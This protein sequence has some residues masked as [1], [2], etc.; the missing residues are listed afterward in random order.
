MGILSYPKWKVALSPV[1]IIATLTFLEKKKSSA[2]RFEQLLLPAARQNLNQAVCVG[3]QSTKLN[4]TV[5]PSW[6]PM[7]A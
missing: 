2:L 3:V 7:S 5:L 6:K 4:K 1:L